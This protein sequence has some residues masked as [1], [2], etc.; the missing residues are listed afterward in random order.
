M[1][2]AR[3]PEKTRKGKTP[4][5][6][7][8]WPKQTAVCFDPNL[9]ISILLQDPHAR[10]MQLVTSILMIHEL[11]SILGQYRSELILRTG[12]I[13]LSVTIL[14]KVLEISSEHSNPIL[15]RS[16]PLIHLLLLRLM[17]SVCSRARLLRCHRSSLHHCRKCLDS[18]TVT[19]LR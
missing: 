18:C 16:I 10:Q 17:P 7:N 8:F 6:K 3:K 5:R 19:S 4:K 11:H 15:D 13:A 12:C 14:Q 9:G 1:E 2:V